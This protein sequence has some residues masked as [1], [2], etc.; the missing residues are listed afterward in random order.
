MR[1]NKHNTQIH[2]HIFWKEIAFIIHGKTYYYQH[3]MNILVLLLVSKKEYNKS[4]TWVKNAKI[5]G[6]LYNHSNKLQGAFRI[7]GT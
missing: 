2:K 5:F 1:K 7:Y 3:F 4:V 6:T